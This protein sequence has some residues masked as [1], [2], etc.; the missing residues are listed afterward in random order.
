MP[1]HQ[2]KLVKVNQRIRE[3]LKRIGFWDDEVAFR[4]SE[5][6]GH[7]PLDLEGEVRDL[8]KGNLD[9]NCMALLQKLIGDCNGIPLRVLGIPSDEWED[10]RRDGNCSSTK[11]E[12]WGLARVQD[13]N[14]LKPLPAAFDD[15]VR[16][17]AGISKTF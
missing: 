10:A 17:L 9:L 13:R 16:Y 15:G 11:L 5:A 12:K 4:V 3:W 14:L 2:L 7:L 6:E 1:R 8:C